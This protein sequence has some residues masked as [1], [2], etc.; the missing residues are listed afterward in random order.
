MQASGVAVS[1]LRPVSAPALAGVAPLEALYRRCA[2]E[3]AAIGMDHFSFLNVERGP[4]RPDARYHASY[5][6]AWQERYL[7][8]SLQNYDPV[9]LTARRRLQAFGWDGEAFLRPF[10]DRQREVFYE[11]VE[12]GIVYGFSVPVHAPEGDVFLLTGATRFA[13]A[14]RAALASDRLGHLV[15]L[16]QNI[17]EFCRAAKDGQGQPIELSEACRDCLYWTSVGKTSADIAQ[18]MGRSVATVNYHLQRAIKA[19]GAANKHHAA[20]IAYRSGLI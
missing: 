16:G 13:E 17:A 2:E 15:M 20:L 4:A 10:S 14:A 8:G 12:F 11:C 3:F 1:S 9:V 7:A 18:I 19:L 6:R 5:P